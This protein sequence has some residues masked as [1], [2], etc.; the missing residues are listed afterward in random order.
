MD[1]IY[2]HLDNPEEAALL[3]RM[4]RVEDHFTERKVSSDLKDVLKTLVAFG[5]STPVNS[6]S[7]LYLGVRDNG[8]IEVPQPDL[9]SIQRTYRKELAKIYP[10]LQTIVVNLEENGL[11]AL[12]AVVPHSDSKPHFG[13]ASWV[14]VGSATAEATKPQYEELIAYR[15]SKTA[16]ILE[17]KGKQVTVMNSKWLNHTLREGYWGQTV[18]VHRCNAFY[19]TLETPDGRYSFNLEMVTISFDDNANRLLL[20]L[21]R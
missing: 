11:H 21:D 15:N 12:A 3:K 20:K 16:K 7:V 19:V 4:R 14:R 10:P 9:E 13:G 2:M 18:I 6:T 1:T 5:N 8:E 17:Y